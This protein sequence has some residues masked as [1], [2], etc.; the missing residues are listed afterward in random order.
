M[1]FKNQDSSL[2]LDIAGYEFPQG[3]GDPASDDQNWLVLRCTWVREDG[4]VVKDTNSCLLTYE[5]NCR[6]PDNTDRSC[7]KE[8]F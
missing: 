5:L 2:K 8:P 1:L 3:G 4:S 7:S 6:F